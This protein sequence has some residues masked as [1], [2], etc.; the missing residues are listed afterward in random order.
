MNNNFIDYKTRW[1][2][3]ANGEF[4]YSILFIKAWLPFNAWYCNSYPNLNNNDRRIL[5]E[6]KTGNTL[7]KTRIISLL[8]G[9]NEDSIFFKQKLLQLHNQL[10]L[11]KVPS[12]AKPITFNNINFRENPNPVFNK[13]HRNYKFKIELITPIPPHNNKVKIDILNSTNSNILAYLHTKYDIENLKNNHDFKQLSESNQNIIIDGFEL[14]NPKF[15]ESLIATRKSESFPHIKDVFFINNSDLLAQGI[16]EILYNLR[17]I[18]FH[19]EIQPSKDNL[20]IY[21]P[22][23]YMLRLLI[24]SLD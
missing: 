15:R 18:L 4:E 5:S 2:R 22:A 23:F 8:E 9:S 24:K 6:I 20:K 7:F 3:I 11:C 10:E 1:L 13:T 21:E 17:C 16:I 19:G 14:V 12:T